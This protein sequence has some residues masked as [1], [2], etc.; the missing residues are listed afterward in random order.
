[1]HDLVYVHMSVEAHVLHTWLEHT[2][3]ITSVYTPVYD[4]IKSV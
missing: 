4:E 1:M 2:N 3:G